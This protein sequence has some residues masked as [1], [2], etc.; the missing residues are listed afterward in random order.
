M[1]GVEVG[2]SRCRETQKGSVVRGSRSKH[3]EMESVWHRQ[4]PI[5]AP[6]DLTLAAQ[7]H[8]G[9]RSLSQVFPWSSDQSFQG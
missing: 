1:D 6:S 4:D 5:L 3:R 8:G 9:R 2:S 7:L